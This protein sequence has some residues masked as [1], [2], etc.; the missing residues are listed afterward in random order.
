MKFASGKHARAICDRCGLEYRLH[1]LRK[2][3]NNLKVCNSCWEP[4]HPQLGLKGR[5]DRVA[6]MDPR[7]GSN[8]R[9]DQTVYIRP[10]LTMHGFSGDVVP[11]KV[12][13]GYII[14]SG[15]E[16]TSSLGSVSLFIDT[17][18]F[19]EG[20]STTSSLGNAFASISDT[21]NSTGFQ[22]NTNT[23]NVGII[24]DDEVMPAGLASTTSLG[25]ATILIDNDVWGLDT[26]NF[27]A[28]GQ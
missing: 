19:P 10:G 20:V 2:E 14:P 5:S 22:I 1:E 27:G 4:K 15:F 23:P 13:D 16:I 24:V 11:I 12:D 17:I 8:S 25:N 18:L 3:W 7:P 6:I 26:W 9:E 28:W 21:A